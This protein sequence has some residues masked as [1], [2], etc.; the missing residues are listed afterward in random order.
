MF[1]KAGKT[2]SSILKPKKVG[3]WYY[4]WTSDDGNQVTQECVVD[5]HGCSANMEFAHSPINNVELVFYCP[6][7]QKLQD[8]GIMH[9]A[10][11]SVPEYETITVGPSKPS[12]QDYELGKNDAKRGTLEHYKYLAEG[13]HP[14]GLIEMYS[15][16]YKDDQQKIISA[17]DS[18]K[19]ISMDVISVR[20]RKCATGSPTLSH[21]IKT[22]QKKGYNYTKIHLA[23]C[24]GAGDSPAQY[25]TG[26]RVPSF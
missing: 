14:R 23:I 13:M 15:Q 2:G 4:A 24:R 10:R 19:N 8:P 25:D 16:F 9:F 26:F 21:V 1:S 6:H 7:G 20:N 5:A 18:I 12:Y 11:G 3:D 17:A 22:L